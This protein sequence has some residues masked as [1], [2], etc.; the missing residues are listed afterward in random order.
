M[1]L[2]VAGSYVALSDNTHEPRSETRSLVVSLFLASWGDAV[3]G[4]LARPPGRLIQSLSASPQVE[5]LVVVNPPRSAAAYTAKRM[6]KRREPDLPVPPHGR[7]ELL[8]PLGWRRRATTQV[9][10]SA[11]EHA[12]YDRIVGKRL[13]RLDVQSPSLITFSPLVAAFCKL[14]WAGATVYYA[15]DDW[16]KH[17]R[18]RSR[19]P[20]YEE[21]YRRLRRRGIPVVAVS[22]ELLDRLGPTGPAEV[23]PNGI[24]EAEWRH[25]PEPPAW[26][27]DLPRPIFVY[28][29][30]LDGRVDP[31][32]L[33]AVRRRFPEG[34]LVLAGPLLPGHQ[35]DGLLAQKNVYCRHLPDRASIT[36]LVSSADVCLLPHHRTPLTESMNP[37]KL[38]EYLAAGRPVAATDLAGFRD[39][40]PKITL[41]D[42]GEAF[43]DA[44][45]AA[46][47]DG[48]MD[49]IARLAFIDKNRW[50]R[51]HERLRTLLDDIA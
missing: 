46:L 16:T 38:Y 34:S 33:N 5:T 23:L 1:S 29:G 42:E 41:S 40:H 2:V 9:S 12:R 4:N 30:M 35:L 24:D 19:W 28:V 18:L 20:L 50:S 14:D 26:V 21:A 49:E 6:L 22:S 31:L 32:A 44:A 37:L 51:R 25:L 11:R 17:P 48:P 36:G 27:E 39:L 13:A 8:E 15:R 45:E 3:R 7:S 10:V 43:A 47:L